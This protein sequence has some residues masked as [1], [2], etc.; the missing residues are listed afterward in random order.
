MA[1]G[2]NN[3]SY[4]ARTNHRRS[5]VLFGIKQ[6]DR[7]QHVYI[8]GQTGV[9]KST[10]LKT[11]ALQ[12]FH[13]GRG[14]ALIDPHGD[15][16]EELW[17]AMPEPLRERVCYLNAP[18]PTQPYGY[19]PLRRV[20]DD[21][22]PLAASGLLESLKKLWPDAWGIR[23]EHL[24][25]NSL[26]TLLERD[27]ATLVDLLRL[28]ADDGFRRSVTRGVR[29]EIVRRFWRDEFE[30]YHPRYRAEAV[31]PVQNKLGALLSDPTLRRI[32]AEPAVDLHFRSLM[33]GGHVLLVNLAKGSIGADSASTLGSLLVSTL[34]LAALTRADL[35][36]EARRPF[37][38]FADEF[39]TFTT[40]SFANMMA[41]LRKY[42]VSLT[43]AHQH[44]HQLD[45]DVRHA[46]LGNA[47]SLVTFRLGAEDAVSVARQ[48]APFETADLTNLPNSA[49]YLRLMIDGVPSPAFSAQ[50]IVPG[51]S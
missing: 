32:L 12:D 22:I 39:Q 34:G 40:L 20:R 45:P 31:A 44:L 36:P 23:M 33:D 35:P 10:L 47:G 43:L 26:Y 16:V 8:I 19:N 6:A 50:T 13:A 51:C 38:V 18:D 30:K 17:A 5:N 11:L 46:V 42:G 1:N 48:F 49:I 28:Y 29:N 4:I 37:H 3:I 21:M 24:L 25:R 14:F 41:D 7:L 2:S 27:N 9:G 15:M